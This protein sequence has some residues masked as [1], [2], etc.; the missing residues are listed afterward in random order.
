MLGLEA[1][2]LCGVCFFEMR[3]RGARLGK[4][5]CEAVDG[6]P[7]CSHKWIGSAWPVTPFRYG[8][9]KVLIEWQ[10]ELSEIGCPVRRRGQKSRNGRLMLAT[11][12]IQ[13]LPRIVEQA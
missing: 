9:Q 10:R 11:C 13:V 6:I 3:E 1:R 12:L 8:I 7:A 2:E 4:V 5:P